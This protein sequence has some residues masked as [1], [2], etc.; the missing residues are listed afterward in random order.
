V[1]RANTPWQQPWT[2]ATS[3]WPNG[4]HITLTQ[5]KIH[6][7]DFDAHA[8]RH[9]TTK[10]QHPGHLVT[11]RKQREPRSQQPEDHSLIM[12]SKQV[13]SITADHSL[14]AQSQVVARLVGGGRWHQADA[15]SVEPEVGLE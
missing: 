3:K 5:S 9:L 2:P 13:I 14:N 15:G 10:Q 8:Q 11:R 1:K 4:T 7:I 6:K 12:E